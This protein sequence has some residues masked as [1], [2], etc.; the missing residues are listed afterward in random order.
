MES[1][2]VD[3]REG[4]S[5]SDAQAVKKIVEAGGLLVLPTDTVYGIG[6]D[7]Y[8]TNA[9][10]AVLAA[11][12][13]GRQMPPPVLIADPEDAAR[14]SSQLNEVAHR[15]IGAFWPGALTLIVKAAEGIR[16]DLGDIKDT[17]AIRMP[18]HEATLGVLRAVGPLAVTSANLTGQPAA[19]SV[20]EA[21]EYFGEGVDC[22]IDSGPTPAPVPSTIIDV[23]ADVPVLLRAGMISV[24][25]IEAACGQKVLI[26]K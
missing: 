4:I 8:S 23:T 21:I 15:L 26:N 14:V 7:P 11:K 19:T 13:R 1:M 5:P 22:Y 16:F 12:G 6:A 10:N 17:V 9:V 3:A 2:K 24:A 20:E 25:D 18:N